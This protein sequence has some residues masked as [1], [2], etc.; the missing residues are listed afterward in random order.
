MPL[1]PFHWGPSSWIGLSLL[2]A[3]DFGAF[4]IGSVIVDIEPFCVVIF[5]LDYPLHGFLHTF[6][7]GTIIT[8]ILSMILYRFKNLLKNCMRILKLPHNVSYRAILF[9]C[10]LGA[11]LHVI[12][13]SFLYTDI[14]PLFPSHANPF[15]GLFSYGAV[16]L[17]CTFSFVVGGVAYIVIRIKHTNASVS[18]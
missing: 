2:R 7:G 8:V 13:D 17:F 1:T 18:R 3:V 6:L 16:Y 4:L 10:L 12:L 15:Y 9:G 14:R 11:Y 5:G